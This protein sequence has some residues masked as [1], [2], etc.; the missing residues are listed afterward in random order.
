M[1]KI[2]KTLNKY[3]KNYL[4]KE[5]ENK[6]K[7]RLY[8]KDLE[9]QDLD[10]E[11][12]DDFDFID[13][14]IIKTSF[15]NMKE[16]QNKFFEIKQNLSEYWNVV[17]YQEKNFLLY[18]QLDPFLQ[19]L[20]SFKK[21][22]QRFF[23]AYFDDLLNAYYDHQMLIFD[24]KAFRKYLYNFKSLVNIDN[25]YKPESI[26]ANFSQVN[27]LCEKE[28]SFVCYSKKVNRFYLFN[29]SKS[30]FGFSA[31]LSDENIN[32]IA[33]MILKEDSEALMNYILENNLGKK[34]LLKRL[35]KIKR[36]KK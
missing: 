6:S 23:I 3:N 36:K 33:K 16:I 20:K 2:E 11:I 13:F 35:K 4:F 5:R 12:K 22:D 27:L 17:T 9:K 14:E 19:S 29:D 28:D 24:K 31:D 15:D 30:S 21:K 10:L 32:A 34:R 18:K 25:L 1:K 7:A 26:K 8:K